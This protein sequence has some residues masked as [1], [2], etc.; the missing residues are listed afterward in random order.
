M[1][2]E[3]YVRFD[4]LG[5]AELVATGQVSA[6]ELLDTAIARADAVNPRLNAIVR[7]FDARAR[8]QL[9]QLPAGPFAG[10]PF[11]IKDLMAEYAGEP[12]SCG[13]RLFADY[14][15]RQDS[16]LVRRYKA[17][18]LVIF[19]KT[20]T[21]EFGLTPF[22]EPELFGP[23]RNPWNPAHTPGGSSGGSGAAVASGIVPMANGGDGGGSIRIPASC[24]GLVG[25]KPSRGLIPL[26]PELG[27]SWWGFATEHVI[28]RSVRDTAAALDA[29]AGPDPGCPYFTQPAPGYR[30]ALAQ[31]PPRLRIAF[32]VA[33]MVGRSM[34]GECRKGLEST[35]RLLESLGH[36]L[37][38]AAPTIE[39]EVFIQSFVTLLAADTAGTVTARLRVLAS[40]D[41]GLVEPGTRALVHIGR[42]VSGE[43]VA[44]ARAFFS[45]MTRRLGRWFEDYDMLL[46]PTLG[47]PPFRVGALQPSLAERLQVGLLNSLPLARLV[48]SGQMLQQVAEKTFEW[49]PNT[50][51]FNV[52]GQPSISLPLHWSAD[53]LPVGM[54]LSAR[55]AD[56]LRLLQLSAQIEQAQPWFDRRPSI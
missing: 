37:V 11:L 23:A 55:L 54:M 12:L 7:R 25:L 8:E 19:G 47:L 17:A 42:A 32:S 51:V 1:K 15:P 13:S 56:D 38:E 53:G 39:R 16:E 3:E 43:E 4:A 26:G 2:F 49:M 35:V 33:P 41:L 18:G 20:N 21:P 44:L 31:K 46:T 29:T 50:A 30:A 22:T 27:E 34:H 14:L 24:N 48:K 9:A 6:A 36:E 28:A 5:L 45:Q 52:S 40:T 10:V